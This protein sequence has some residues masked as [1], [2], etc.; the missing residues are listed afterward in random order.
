[1]GLFRRVGRHVEQFK[2]TATEAAAQEGQYQCGACDE[3]FESPHDEC[4]ECGV[5]GRVS[6]RSE[7]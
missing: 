2:Q 6:S 7:A 5:T 4:P 3:R 1:M